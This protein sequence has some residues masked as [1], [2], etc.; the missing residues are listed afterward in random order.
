[1]ATPNDIYGRGSAQHASASPPPGVHRNAALVLAGRSEYFDVLMNQ[2]ISYE[3]KSVRLLPHVG[4]LAESP[5]PND[6]AG[7]WMSQLF[8]RLSRERNVADP[9]IVA[10]CT[11]VAARNDE[12]FLSALATTTDEPMTSASSNAVLIEVVTAL[13]SIL[14]GGGKKTPS[15][16]ERMPVGQVRSA[17]VSLGAGGESR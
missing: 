15:H 8:P 5:M 9:L 17:A 1:M 16:W 2:F 11:F 6:S 13:P 4:A 3:A 7:V 14:P 12:A 10:G